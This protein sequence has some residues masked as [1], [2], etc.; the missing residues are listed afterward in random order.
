MR[1]MSFMLTT[2]QVRARTKL[3]TRRI[4]WLDAKPGQRV[5][6]IEKGQGLRKGE[7]VRKLAMIEFT[8]V[9][10]EPLADI[11]THPGDVALEGFPQMSEAEFVAMF[12]RHHSMRSRACTPATVI[13]RLAFKYVR[14]YPESSST[15]ERVVVP[16]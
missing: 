6:A 15:P 12:C 3:V 8:E 16:E 2:P 10:R 1:M 5:I 14:T 11:A 13:T 9:N 4:G 7:C